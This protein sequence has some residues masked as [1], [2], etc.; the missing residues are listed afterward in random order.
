MAKVRFFISSSSVTRREIQPEPVS[1]ARA[2]TEYEPEEDQVFYREKLAEAVTLGGTD[3]TDIM[4]ADECEVFTFEVE[5][6]CGSAWDVRWIGTFTRFDCKVNY[7]RCS[8]EVT[9]APTDDY[10]CILSNWEEK[11]NVHAAGSAITVET[12]I[13]D[14]EISCC[15]ITTTSAPAPITLPCAGTSGT[16]WCL[17]YE[18]FYFEQVQ[19][20]T[21]KV[22]TCWER[23]IITTSGGAP[24]DGNTWTL[25][26][27]NTYYRCPASNEKIVTPMSRGRLFNTCFSELVVGLGCGLTLRSHFYGINTGGHPGAAP[28]NDAYT[29]AAANLRHQTLH[30]K[31][32]VKRPNSS[33]A[34]LS[35]R[36]SLSLKDLL[37]D[38]ATLHNV[39]WAV[40]GNSLIVEHL[41][42]F[43]AN[44]GLDLS[45]ADL[46]LTYEYDVET[47]KREVYEH[48]DEFAYQKGIISYGCGGRDES[49]KLKLFSLD[50]V[51]IQ[52]VARAEDVSD[53]GFV[54]IANAY[55]GTTYRM[56]DA[57][58]PNLWLRLFQNLQ[59]HGRAFGT[60]NISAGP[61]T[62]L[63]RRPVRKIAE[64]DTCLPCGD[65]FEPT[66]TVVTALGDT[67][68][69]GARYDM[70][71]D[72]LTLNL[73]F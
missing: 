31:S 61:Q 12:F 69:L 30:Q 10:E 67:R 41:S 19:G 43:E 1:V 56:I 39:R 27:G 16:A 29:Y 13:G 64:V 17:P 37:D 55:D 20:T 70:H 18:E 8:L 40:V 66:D 73:G 33:N 48:M 72:Q 47:P 6:Y 50:V 51:T 54:L 11:D 9:P 60:Y 38:L 42:Y 36:W 5:R 34:A 46:R 4:A 2:V 14:Y 3:Y 63:S 35:F 32:D 65:T 68:V 44:T 24:T 71:R 49:K 28:S 21:Y 22:R 26:S 25:I 15:E 58:A 59:R 57:N 45:A 53:D 62:A 7:N 52:D 23:I